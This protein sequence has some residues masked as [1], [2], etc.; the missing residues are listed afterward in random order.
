MFSKKYFF[1]LN[2]GALVIALALFANYLYGTHETRVVNFSPRGEIAEVENVELEFSAPLA[3]DTIF[4]DT[5]FL[6]PAVAGKTTLID[7]H[8]LRFTSE[9]PFVSATSYRIGLANNLRDDRGRLI[10]ADEMTFATPALRL[11]NIEPIAYDKNDGFTIALHFNQAV[12][13]EML[14][15]ALKING[16]LATTNN[17]ND[18]PTSSS[19]SDKIRDLN[20]DVLGKMSATPRISL[21][22]TR[23]QKV[24]FK[25]P[26][27]F[28]GVDGTRGLPDAINE[29]I[30]LLALTKNMDAVK[31]LGLQ[32][33]NRWNDER[34]IIVRT[35]TPLSLAHAAQYIEVEPKTVIGFVP[36]Y[37]GLEIS[38]NFKA[39]TR[40]QVTLKS[41]FPA[42]AVGNLQNTITRT[43]WFDDREP[44][45]KFPYGGGYLTPNGLLTVP[46]NTVNLREIKVQTQKMY[47]NNIVEYAI[48]YHEWNAQNL[49]SNIGEQKIKTASAKNQT[50]ETLLNLRELLGE[51][52]RGIYYLSA[53]NPQS[54]QNTNAAL[55]ITDLGIAA[56]ISE[57]QA[58]IWITSLTTATPQENVIVRV[59]SDRRQEIAQG[60]TDKNGV[61]ILA[62]PK[63]PAEENVAICTAE[64]GDDLSYLKFDGNNISRDREITGGKII[65]GQY[66]IFTTTERGVYRAGE[67]ALISAMARKNDNATPENLYL[68]FV[69]TRPDKREFFRQRIA[70]DQHGRILT[71]VILPT[72]A[73]NGVYHYSFTLPESKIVLGNGSFRVT[74]FMPPTLKMTIDAPIENLSA[75]N[76]FN[77]NAQVTHLFGT[78]AINLPTKLR[79]VFTAQKFAP[80]NSEWKNYLFNDADERKTPSHFSR[81]ES[82]NNAGKIDFAVAI[83][84]MNTSGI[85]NGAFTVEVTENGGRALCENF[86][87]DFY[88]RENYVGVKIADTPI[89]AQKS[90]TLKLCAI[91]PAEKLSTQKIKFTAQLSRVN[92]VNVLRGDG[93]ILTYEWSKSETR[94]SEFNGEIIGGNGEISFTPQFAGKYRLRLLT[95]T[96]QTIIY[97]FYAVGADGVIVEHSPN[98]VAIIADKATYKIGENVECEINAPFAGTALI[99]LENDQVRE[100]RIEQFNAG[101]NKITFVVGETW[102]PNIYITATLIR[103]VIAEENWQAHRVN[104]VAVINVDCA[105]KKLKVD[106][107]LPEKMRPAQKITA[108][109]KITNAQNE[110]AKN[111]A[112]I[113]AA[114]DSG[115]LSLTNFKP[116]SPFN[117]FY[118]KRA[119]RVRN[120]DMYH[121][122]SPE[123][124]KWRARG[125]S[126]PGGGDGGDNIIDN[127]AS[128]LTPIIAKRVKTAV[129]YAGNLTTDENGVVNVD[130]TLPDYLGELNFMIFSAQDD[131]FGVYEKAATIAAPIMLRAGLPRFLAPN[132]EF[133]LP[134]TIFNQTE[135]TQDIRVKIE[136]DDNIT[137]A[138]ELTINVKNNGEQNVKIPLRVQDNIGVA[139]IKISAIAETEEYSEVVELPI[140]P[141]TTKAHYAGGKTIPAGENASIKLRGDFFGGTEKTHVLITGNPLAPAANAVK[142]LLT[143]P[144][145]CLEQTISRALTMISAPDLVNALAENSIGQEECENLLNAALA[146]LEN[147]QQHSGGFSAWKNDEIYDWGTIYAL[148]LFNRAKN[149]GVNV[150]SD[151]FNRTINYAQNVVEKYTTAVNK[152]GE[153]VDLSLAV[154]ACAM[155]TNAEFTPF[156]WLARL[157]EI[158]AEKLAGKIF[159]ANLAINLATIYLKLGKPELAESLYKNLPLITNTQNISGNLSSPITE[160]AQ[161]LALL[162]EVNPH[163]EKIPALVVALANTLNSRGLN[164]YENA[165]TMLA[166]SKYARI[167][168]AKLNG[169][170]II[171]TLSNGEKREINADD[172][173]QINDLKIGEVITIDAPKNAPQN[174]PIYVAWNTSGQMRTIIANE[175]GDENNATRALK[176]TRT[177]YDLNGKI[178]A[179][180]NIIAGE[181]YYVSLTVHSSIMLPNSLI[182]DLLPAGLEIENQDLVNSAKKNNLASLRNANA[183]NENG[184]NRIAG[185]MPLLKPRHCE[186]RDD[187]LLLFA[188]FP[189]GFSRYEYLIRAVTIGDFIY[190]AIYAENMY[191]PQIYYHGISEKMKVQAR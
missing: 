1:I 129:L 186:T 83:P 30:D 74:D 102:R 179:P 77:I 108:Q 50:H 187:R 48:S 94:E 139:K 44:Q 90:T 105:E 115:V 166:L 23:Y 100:T 167:F 67:T 55:V 147:L 126:A 42:G 148:D 118:A 132:D 7:A 175:N 183:T 134:I 70:T 15:S 121:R 174:S 34:A 137:G 82:L 181:L 52:P 103:P 12:S 16:V 152:N 6:S 75:K 128:E 189:A 61:A 160:Q 155:L 60:K 10:S 101:K 99:C 69:V 66:T 40:Y 89:N 104:G 141:P 191:N 107:Q 4:P 41:G 113:L 117:F 151:L 71:N 124:A 133:I 37:E 145:G 122:L 45:I 68:D 158:I 11:L 17:K 144:Y 57:N 159:P 32:T 106:L 24:A 92:Y 87:R 125:I 8:R 149:A 184:E 116:S 177:L 46:I 146:R 165:Q 157:E 81:E 73:A 178:V 120:I 163:D 26:L 138:Q 54:Y 93:E 64:L 21:R 56:R 86:T 49:T 114:V 153:Y 109:I 3:L 72:S 65:D 88:P 130:L 173:T 78:P 20:F 131:Y 28:C 62:L 171:L 51:N 39:G 18:L 98:E 168:P 169:E 127:L 97:D 14:K 31:F 154:Y 182:V 161:I 111:V 95:E 27:G 22:E 5:I 170:K 190:P 140:R 123:L 143:Y 35:N 63:L 110:P 112:V 29:E 47:V 85:I 176:V 53:N 162:L 96:A 142:N 13:P 150:P 36:H 9:K 59:F 119:L 79:A 2:L 76:N 43:V 136:L 33:Q 25:L 91:T 38:G 135:T 164:T 172:F 185:E 80:K 84:T 156:S 188:D 19:P 58:V 180:E